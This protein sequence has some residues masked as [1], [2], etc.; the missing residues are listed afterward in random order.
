V[1]GV[2]VKAASNRR[3]PKLR[4]AEWGMVREISL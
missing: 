2:A 4:I 3:T 1:R